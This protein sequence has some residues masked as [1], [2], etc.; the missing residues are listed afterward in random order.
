[1]GGERLPYSLRALSSPRVLAG[2]L[3][4]LPD[5]PAGAQR[6]TSRDPFLPS[7]PRSAIIS[8]G[9]PPTTEIPPMTRATFSAL[10]LLAV[11]T[12][13]HAAAPAKS[14]DKTPSYQRH[15]SALL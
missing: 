8:R 10:V 11:A 15:V 12:S 5:E 14:D 2:E 4:H 13:A 3:G 7:A 1:M 9:P 6:R